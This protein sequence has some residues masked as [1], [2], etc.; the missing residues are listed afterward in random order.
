MNILI[1]GGT[2]F[3]GSVLARRCAETGCRVTVVGLA[4]N[5]WE[6][7]RARDLSDLG[8]EVVIGSV[9]DRAL[10]SDACRGRDTL[11]H[12]AAAQHE[13]KVKDEYFRR[14]NVD[15]TRNVLAASVDSGVDRFIHGSTIGVY[16]DSQDGPINESSPLNPENIYGKTKL[17]AENVAAEFGDRLKLT[18]VRISET[19]GPE[20]SRLLPMFRLVSKGWFPLIGS[21]ANMHQPIF[22]S[23]LANALL[24]LADNEAA[25]GQ[26]VILAGPKPVSTVEMINSVE[27]ALGHPSRKLKVPLVL[28]TGAA[29]VLESLLPLLNVKPPLTRRRLDFYRKNF[30]FDASKAAEL[31]GAFPSVDFPTGASLTLQWYRANG[32]LLSQPAA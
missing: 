13:S 23:D 15:G 18:I 14:I 6:S 7:R 12:L 4:N 9:L 1:T 29:H 8:I 31:T 22:V 25:V 28:M 32:L 2:G 19:Y 26:T 24:A 16:G 30:W 27:R 10:I 20:D 11:V 17:E 5:D 3:I 21:G